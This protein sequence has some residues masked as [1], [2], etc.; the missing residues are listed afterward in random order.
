MPPK[1]KASRADGPKAAPAAAA[2]GPSP[3]QAAA[4][5]QAADLYKQF[6]KKK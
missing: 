6:K 3:D 1:G 2:A 4:A 5:K